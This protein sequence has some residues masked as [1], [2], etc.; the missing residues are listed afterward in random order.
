MSL[1]RSDITNL[2]HQI[3][4]LE[5]LQETVDLLPEDLR[6]FLIAP[7]L[8]DCT[9]A[10]LIRFRQSMLNQFSDEITPL[11]SRNINNQI[12]IL[13]T[14]DGYIG[15]LPPNWAGHLKKSRNCSIQGLINLRQLLIA[16][17]A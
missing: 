11:E 3:D 5:T 6:R 12:K 9:I 17:F 13:G 8:K 4:L 16:Q 2:N 14:I 7:K 1:S 10:N 15:L